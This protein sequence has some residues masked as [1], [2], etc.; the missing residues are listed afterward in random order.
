MAG[1]SFTPRERRLI[2]RL[3]TPLQVQRWLNA[4][5]Y[6]TEPDG[7][8]QRSFR[9]VVAVGCAHCMEAA[10][11]AA[12][13]LEVHGW[14]PLVMS[15]ESE[16][17]LDHVLFVYRTATGWGSIGR[18]RD[19]GLH[20]RRP[21]FR[22]LRDLACS[23]VEPYVDLT[24]RITGY[25]VL[26]LRTLRG[27]DWRCSTRNLWLVEKVLIEMPHRPLRTCDA[28]IDVLRRRYHAFMAAH[29]GFKPLGYRGQ[30]KWHPLPAVFAPS[31]RLA[32]RL[33]HLP[34]TA[35]G[36]SRGRRRA[37]DV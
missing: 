21:V 35:S 30:E 3:R 31:V 17:K 23:Y 36:L 19:P 16:D 6:N 13:I 29:A 4:M 9:S 14:P 28:R 26:D 32:R 10:M 20:G 37:R 27:Y 18:S 25:G 2:A 5:P 22:T 7:E 1:C 24:G 12:T 15:L 33:G 11:S 8:T 34:Q